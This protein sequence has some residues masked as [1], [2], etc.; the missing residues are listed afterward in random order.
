[1][2]VDEA[3]AIARQ[4][5]EAL[6]A[7]HEQG[8][9]HRDLKPSNIAVR[10]D[11]VVKVLDFGIARVVLAPADAA[12]V[13]SAPT[14]TSTSPEGALLGTPAYMSPEQAKG[15][16]ADKR[17]DIWAFGAVLFEMLSGRRVFTGEGAYDTL[18]AVLHSEVEWH[19]LPAHTPEA[20][21]H[22]MARCLTRDPRERLRDMGEAR[23]ALSAANQKAGSLRSRWWLAPSLVGLPV[24]VVMMA[25]LVATAAMVA[26]VA[27]NLK[28]AVA[29]QLARFTFAYPEGRVPR[30]RPG[31]TSSR[32]RPMELRSCKRPSRLDFNFAA[33]RNLPG[34]DP[35][36]SRV[37][38]DLRARPFYPDGRSIAF[39]ADG[40]IRRILAAGGSAVTITPAAEPMGMHWTSGG[41]L[42]GAG[43][44]GVMRV[45]AEGGL[46]EVIARVASGEE[47]H[48]PQLLPDGRHLLFTIAKG[49]SL[50]R[51]ASARIAVDSLDDG[52]RTTLIDGGTDAR[53]LRSGH[54]VYGRGAVLYTVSFDL[55]R[56]QVTSSPLAMVTGIGTA[57]GQTGA[58]HF[59]TADTGLL[60]Y[61]PRTGGAADGGGQAASSP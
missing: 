31:G 21:R 55:R 19:R 5:A 16:A 24:L 8:V 43:H 35:R 33:C 2:P 52:T 29:P 41:L 23:I 30:L 4:V 51:W 57:F 39:F 60:A 9:V 38:T 14:G 11:G 48:G 56:L 47:A 46:P 12:A 50:D 34:P 45:Q 32:C 49:T 15:R 3:V 13:S 44:A 22:L 54:L 20:L 27:W 40:A 7:A 25:A 36:H 26:V 10:A 58:A 17:S 18:A 59:A 42:Y 1:M 61:E 28:P 6:E 37:S 53:Y